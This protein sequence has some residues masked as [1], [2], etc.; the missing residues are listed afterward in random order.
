MLVEVVM[1]IEPSPASARWG[2]AMEIPARGPLTAVLEE[3]SSSR[4][5]SEKRIQDLG[6]KRCRGPPFSQGNYY[7][8]IVIGEIATDHQLQRARDHLERGE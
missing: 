1:E 6:E 8:L 3:E 7:M 5:G 2:V 4:L